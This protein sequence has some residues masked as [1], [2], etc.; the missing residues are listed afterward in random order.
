MKKI[1]IILLFFCFT[2]LLSAG[3]GTKESPF[4]VQEMKTKKLS[5]TD[6]Y[7]VHGF[8][9]G[10]FYNNSNNKL[11]YEM[12]PWC[13]NFHSAPIFEGG[14]YIIADSPFEHDINK[15]LTIQFPTTALY[16]DYSLEYHPELWRKEFI[17]YGSHETYN[18]VDGMKK[19]DEY[20]LLSTDLSDE[21]IY[22]YF[23][24]DFEKSG[25]PPQNGDSYDYTNYVLIDQNDKWKGCTFY[26]YFSYGIYLD[27]E[28]LVSS[29]KIVNGVIDDG[30]PKW[31]DL[32]VCLRGENASITLTSGGYNIN[33][34]EFWAGNYENY[35][36]AKLSFSLQVSSDGESWKDF[37]SNVSVATP[38][39]ATTN[40]MTLYRYYIHSK[41]IYYFRIVKTDNN[42]GK[43]LQIDNLKYSR[44]NGPTALPIIKD[45]EIIVSS[46]LELLEIKNSV[47][48]KLSIYS[49]LGKQVY[50]AQLNEQSNITIPLSSGVYI[51]RFNDSV[52]KVIIEN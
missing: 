43:G 37:A 8:V 7:Y 18:G 47:A 32:A 2:G 14:F 5:S 23:T 52:K 34:V 45:D 39:N 19:I 41:D 31:D 51:V 15:C 29:Y 38:S 20:E 22:W 4:S 40:G 27:A 13:I 36:S 16:D 12:S 25:T 26:H 17:F 21:S 3:N 11:F 9:V 10:E 6:K 48:G 44:F 50:N 35:S 33:E 30:K 46:H 49:V 28:L 1:Y 42:I 24:D